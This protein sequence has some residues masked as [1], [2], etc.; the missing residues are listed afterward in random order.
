MTDAD[1]TPGSDEWLKL[2]SASKV[3]GI[4]GHSPWTSPLASWFEMKGLVP[5]EE[6]DL[7]ENSPL[8]RGQYLEPAILQ[9][10]RDRHEL[11]EYEE[12]VTARLGDWAI[13]TYDAKALTASFEHI[14]IE[15]K[16]T[17]KW[18]GWG[19]KGTDQIPKYYMS[20]VW[21]QFLLD[22][23][24]ERIYVPVI[25]PGLEFREYV[26][27]RPSSADL[28]GMMEKV[29]AFYASLSHDTPPPLDGHVA[30]LK[31]LSRLHL[32]IADGEIATVSDTIAGEY[33]EAELALKSAEE[34]S[35]AAKSAIVAEVGRAHYIESESGIRVARR[36]AGR[37]GGPPY[38]VRTARK[39]PATQA[40]V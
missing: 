4:L 12:Q 35:R 8:T 25:G 10:W 30:T 9:W 24:I 33:I 14:A 2:V 40:T 1:L 15:A 19:P 32:G 28:N 29:Y 11:L 34:R 36:Q 23:K 39:W 3:A 38:L 7:G 17:S 31:T 13:C 6:V 26:V 16:S 20:Q 18:E 21:W 5:R 22:P 37:N 27:E